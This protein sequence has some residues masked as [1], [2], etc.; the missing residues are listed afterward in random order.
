MSAEVIFDSVDSNLEQSLSGDIIKYLKIAGLDYVVDSGAIYVGPLLVFI[1][2]KGAEVRFRNRSQRHRLRSDPPPKLDITKSGAKDYVVVVKAT[3]SS[4]EVIDYIDNLLNPAGVRVRYSH[5]LV[6]YK[7]AI[8]VQT[9][10]TSKG[11]P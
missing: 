7:G 8:Y 9:N 2:P 1:G 5:A 4:Q 6:A 10:S 3:K 11:T